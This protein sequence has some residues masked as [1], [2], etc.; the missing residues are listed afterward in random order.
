MIVAWRP[1]HVERRGAPRART[2]MRKTLKELSNVMYVLP[3]LL[4]LAGCGSNGCGPDAAQKTTCGAGTIG[5]K[6]SDG[7]CM[8]VPNAN[9]LSSTCS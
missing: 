3:I 1:L 9:G 7:S 2:D 8:C 5:Q 6:Q 4:A